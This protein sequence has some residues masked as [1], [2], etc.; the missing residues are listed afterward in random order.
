MMNFKGVKYD[1]E[2][3]RE[4]DTMMKVMCDRFHD[5]KARVIVDIDYDKGTCSISSSC[6]ADC[7]FRHSTSAPKMREET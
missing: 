6:K 1:S 5:F 4:Y 3:R 2:I 7:G